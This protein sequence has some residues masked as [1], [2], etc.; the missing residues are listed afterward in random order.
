MNILVLA[1]HADDESLGAGA[2][3]SMW[4]REGHKVTIVA[5]SLGTSTT[6]EFY[7]A[8]HRLGVDKR[9]LTYPTRNFLTHR[10]SILDVLVKL[11]AEYSPD[12]VV[13]PASDDVHQDHQV[14]HAETLRAFI[15]DSSIIGYDYPWNNCQ[16]NTYFVA[17]DRR[18]LV[19]KIRA[20]ECYKS[21]Q[22]R[23]YVSRSLISS[24]ATIRGLMS[25]RECAEAFETIRWRM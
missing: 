3:I 15:R 19:T 11:K 1:P 22:G 9:L 4:L 23:S 12:L 6:A 21:Q 17:I 20:V 18:A 14:I 25:G 13:C 24:L 2:S 16:S 8:T 7:A 10:Q 5:F